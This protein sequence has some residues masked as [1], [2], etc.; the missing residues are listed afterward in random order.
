MS[1]EEKTTYVK[2]APKEAWVIQ[3]VNIRRTKWRNGLSPTD[4]ATMQT[5]KESNSAFCKK[6]LLEF[7]KVVLDAKATQKKKSSSAFPSE[8]ALKFNGCEIFA[9][10]STR[11]L[12]FRADDALLTWIRVG[13]PASVGDSF[14]SGFLVYDG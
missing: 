5:A 4:L 13:S 7:R 14:R 3:Y 8:L 11:Q 2:V 10:S 6:I 12:H 9:R 1:L